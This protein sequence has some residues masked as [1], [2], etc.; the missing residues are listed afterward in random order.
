MNGQADNRRPHIVSAAAHLFRNKGYERATIRD[1]AGAVTLQIGSLFHYFVSKEEI[2]FAVIAEAMN[3]TTT[4]AELALEANH[5][6]LARL[7]ALIGCE[8]EAV[9]GST[10]DGMHVAAFE[11]RKL[12]KDRQDD[13]VEIRNRYEDLWR[14]SL[15]EV[16]QANLLALDPFLARR[17][18]NGALSWTSTWFRPDGS[19]SLKDLT[20]A[21][22]A[23]VL[24]PSPG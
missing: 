1:L 12:S 20:D 3:Q 6:P 7:R 4:R 11:W 15:N 10:A 23:M 5:C 17:F 14:E 19:R 18:L 24:A 9:C 2:L 22:M 13:L 21:A 8:L 16:A